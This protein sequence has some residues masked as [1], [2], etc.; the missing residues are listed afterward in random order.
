MHSSGRTVMTAKTGLILLQA[1]FLGFRKNNWPD[2]DDPRTQPAPTSTWFRMRLTPT[3]SRCRSF[4]SSSCT[5]RPE[6]VWTNLLSNGFDNFFLILT[7]IRKSFSTK[8]WLLLF[9]WPFLLSASGGRNELHFVLCVHPFASIK[10]IVFNPF[11]YWIMYLIIRFWCFG[12]GS[13]LIVK[14]TG[15]FAEIDWFNLQFIKKAKGVDSR[16]FCNYFLK[17]LIEDL[18]ILFFRWPKI[19][20]FNFNLVNFMQNQTRINIRKLAKHIYT[21]AFFNYWKMLSNQDKV[22]NSVSSLNKPT[23]TRDLLWNNKFDDRSLKEEKRYT[24]SY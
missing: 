11:F 19:V 1:D 22:W 10:S 14:I 20:P 15:P 13:T 12:V 6:T 24:L 23:L 17:N 8:C 9:F 7:I 4:S 2:S 16:Y 18:G 3:F 5:C 21:S